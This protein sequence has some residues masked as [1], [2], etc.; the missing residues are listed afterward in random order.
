MRLLDTTS[1][2]IVSVAAD[3]TPP[4]AILSHTWGAEVNEPTLQQIQEL[5]QVGRLD[6]SAWTRHPT[7]LK[8]G[9][10]KI[11]SA[12]GLALAQGYRYLW[13]DTCCIDKTSSAE[14]SEAIN[15]MFKWYQAAGICYVYL[16]DVDVGANI[17]NPDVSR[18]RWFSRGWTLQELVAPANVVFYDYKWSYIGNKRDG[19]GFQVQL[20][21]TTGIDARVLSGAVD[22]EDLSVACRMSWA[23][24]R[25]TSRPEDIAY[26]LIGIFQVNMPLLYGEGSRAF[27]RLQE[28]I[29]RSKFQIIT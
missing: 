18:C 13:A 28:E 23:A 15:S 29:L 22:L 6:P 1:L 25:T 10:Q 14:L 5:T 11:R 24:S 3:K 9:Y 16:E 4:Y 2:D 19:G 20:S 12:C 17:V 21:R 7:A 27:I 26:C 8:K